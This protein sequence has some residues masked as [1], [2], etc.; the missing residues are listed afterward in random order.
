M[1]K[2]RIVGKLTIP[3]PL[4][5]FGSIQAGT[6]FWGNRDRESMVVAVVVSLW[7]GLRDVRLHPNRGCWH[8]QG[9]RIS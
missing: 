7:M 5:F 2:C 9:G 3:C 6:S 8:I 4:R 1:A